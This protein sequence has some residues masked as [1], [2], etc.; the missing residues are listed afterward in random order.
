MNELQ[1]MKPDQSLMMLS[2]MFTNALPPMLPPMK[3]ETGIIPNIFHNI[4]LGQL[5]KASDREARIAENHQR[6]T[7]AKLDVLQ[8]FLTFQAETAD[9]FKDLEHRETIRKLQRELGTEQLNKTR[10]ENQNL[11]YESKISEME[12]RKRDKEFQEE[13]G[14]GAKQ[15]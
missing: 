5:E 2:E 7:I 6:I 14:D 9:R 8:R 3:F 4:K 10:L 11:F 13:Y 12:Y 15:A 1:P